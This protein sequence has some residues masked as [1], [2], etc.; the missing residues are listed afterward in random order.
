MAK[1]KGVTSIKHKDAI[2]WYARV[3]GERVYCGKG[4]KGEELAEAARAKYVAKQYERREIG[5]GLKV[6]RAEI[7][8][9]KALA[10]WYMELD[11]VQKQ[12][13]YGRKVIATA[14]LLKFFGS[15]TLAAV[16]ADD[17][18]RYR[19]WRE[20]QGIASGTIDLELSTMRCMY[21]LAWKRGKINRDIMPRDFVITGETL[22][23][24]TLTDK[25]FESL[26]EHAQDQDFEDMLITGYETAMRVSEILSLTPAQV[27]LDV[28]H[29]S[30]RIL[31]Y[32]ALGC[33]DTKTGARRIVPVSERL[34]DVL[35]RRMDGLET[36]DRIFKALHGSGIAW[37]MELACKGAGIP[38]GDKPK[39]KKG[40][41]TGVVF[42]C[43]RHTRTSKWVQEGFSDE[44][45]RRATGHK[46][47][48]AY[49]R[50]VK[51]GPEHIMRLVESEKPKRHK[52]DITQGAQE[53]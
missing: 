49:Q 28:T 24:R 19:K 10:N 33:F 53:G 35:K 43:L 27:H 37:R 8:T 25:E 9:V 42:H 7:K 21:H 45:V 44:V 11:T 6:R 48:A 1:M 20:K 29:I 12:K 32:I 17:L 41:R 47:L 46:T 34:K 26:L 40:E 39:N 15:K 50:Y 5:A 18:E 36:E 13:I 30:G 22:P 14:H 2:Y 23:R 52:N 4:K 31:N 51:L 3:D 16:E 38:Y